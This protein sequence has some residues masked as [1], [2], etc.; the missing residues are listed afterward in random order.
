MVLV[1]VVVAGL[2][3]VVYMHSIDKSSIP[4]ATAS[5]NSYN[6]TTGLSLSAALSSVS[7]NAGGNIT[8]SVAV[9]NIVHAWTSISSEYDFPVF[10]TPYSFSMSPGTSIHYGFAVLKGNYSASDVQS[11]TPLTIIKPAIFECPA[12]YHVGYLQFM[13][14]SSHAKLYSSSAQTHY[15]GSAD[16][17]GNLTFSGYWTGNYNAPVFHEF[18]P[19]TYTVVSADEWGQT[20]IMHFVVS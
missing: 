10:S 1:S 9:I 15:L 14:N 13:P 20:S 4:S 12:V 19:G 11:G 5:T 16:F 8:V 18:A 17:S 6:Q 2:S 7:I 3:T